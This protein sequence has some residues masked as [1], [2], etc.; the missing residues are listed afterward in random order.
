MHR[1]EFYTIDFE[2]RL[3]IF[4]CMDCDWEGSADPRHQQRPKGVDADHSIMWGPD[5][6]SPDQWWFVGIEPM[7]GVELS[8]GASFSVQGGE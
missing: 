7:P 6:L 3:L 4:R 2:S 1:V 5:L 8:L